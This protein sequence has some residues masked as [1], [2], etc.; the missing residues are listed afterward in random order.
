MNELLAIGLC[1]GVALITL[2][3]SMVTWCRVELRMLN[4]RETDV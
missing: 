1:Y 3:I 4:R 2:T